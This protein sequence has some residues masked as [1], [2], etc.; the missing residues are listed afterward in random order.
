MGCGGM[1]EG[2]ERGGFCA[3]DINSHQKEISLISLKQF[4]GFQIASQ[5]ILAMYFKTATN[6]RT[7]ALRTTKGHSTQTCKMPYNST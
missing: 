2:R 6:I 4:N 3:P 1:G 7:E 5:L